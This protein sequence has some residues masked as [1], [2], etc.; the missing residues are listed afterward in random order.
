M[1]E[2]LVTA[3]PGSPEAAGYGH[4][5]KGWSMGDE[6]EWCVNFWVMPL[7]GIC[8]PSA[9]H[10]LFLSPQGWNEDRVTMNQLCFWKGTRAIFW[11][12]AP[13][14]PGGAE[15]LQ[16]PGPLLPWTCRWQKW[17]FHRA[18]ALLFW[19]LWKQLSQYLKA[20]TH[21]PGWFLLCSLLLL[22]GKPLAVASQAVALSVS[23][24][25]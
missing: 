18:K 20:Y 12:V 23:V 21:F 15:Q 6:W 3:F 14:W 5:S 10:V 25:F 24:M 19:S 4:A 1:A 2:Q 22:M 8:W 7:N 13:D 16:L 17:V 9:F 11:G